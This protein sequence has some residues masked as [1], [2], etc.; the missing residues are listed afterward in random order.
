MKAL[1]LASQSPRRRQLLAEAGIP[2]H[3]LDLDVDETIPPDLAHDPPRVAALLAERKARAAIPL[4][5]DGWI[6]GADTIV[7]LEGVILGKPRDRA[8]ARAMLRALSGSTHGVITGVC[9][10][11][12]PG[13]ACQV[14]VEETRVTMRALEAGEIDA[15]VESGESD[16]KA[17]AYAIQE[18]ADRFVTR[19]D[20]SYSNVVGLPMERVTRLLLELDGA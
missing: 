16:G 10:L 5:R 7:R 12:V 17:G 13:G 14:E 19:L 15:Y 4:V 20:G 6:L 3:A 18:T 2:F 8:E 9:L 11:H 1:Y